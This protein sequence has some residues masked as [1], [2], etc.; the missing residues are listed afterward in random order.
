LTIMWQSPHLPAPESEMR[1]RPVSTAGQKKGI[2]GQERQKQGN[3]VAAAGAGASRSD[4][5]YEPAGKEPTVP[6]P[7]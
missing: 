2:F 1:P 4:R 6:I 7:E 5:W 3:S